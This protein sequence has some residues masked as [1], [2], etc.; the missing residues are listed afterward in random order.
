MYKKDFLKTGQDKTWIS[1]D[2]GIHGFSSYMMRIQED[3]IFIVMLDNT[4]AGMRGGDLEAIADN[5]VPILYQ[6]SANLPNPIAS[7]ELAKR[8]TAQSVGAGIDYFK[9]EV[10]KQRKNFDFIHFENEIN[11][12]A[13][14]FLGSGEVSDAIKLFELLT[15]EFPKSSNAFDSLGEAYFKNNQFGLAKMAYQKSLD[16]DAKNANAKSMI[17]KIEGKN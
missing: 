11:E 8:I 14:G 3:S 9:N 17:E 10:Q 1:H 15:E 2:G 6:K 5:I 4:R 16:L 13:Y 12:I 7:I